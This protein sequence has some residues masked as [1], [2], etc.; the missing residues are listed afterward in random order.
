MA[1]KSSLSTSHTQENEQGEFTLRNSGSSSMDSNNNCDHD[2]DGKTD[3]TFTYE[4]S[5]PSFHNFICNEPFPQLLTYD[6]FAI[7]AA[8]QPENHAPEL[9]H[10]RL[11][12]DS[13]SQQ[14]FST[15]E[16]QNPRKRTRHTL[17]EEGLSWQNAQ[18]EKQNSLIG[19]SPFT[20]ICL[21][22]D[23]ASLPC[24]VDEKINTQQGPTEGQGDKEQVE[25]IDLYTDKKRKQE[26]EDAQL[27]RVLQQQIDNEGW[28]QIKRDEELAKQLAVEWSSGSFVRSSASSS[29]PTKNPL[30]SVISNK[31]IWDKANNS[32]CE[33]SIF[34]DSSN[35]TLQ[36]LDFNIETSSITDNTDIKNEIL[37]MTSIISPS[38]DLS[39]SEQLSDEFDQQPV[40]P[41][42]HINEDEKIISS[43]E[44]F[45]APPF[46]TSSSSSPPAPL[47]DIKPLTELS[48]SN[49]QTWLNS[50]LN[51]SIVNNGVGSSI[52]I[53]EDSNENAEY[54]YSA[55]G[56]GSSLE[57]NFLD[58]SYANMYSGST[59]SSMIKKTQEERLRALLED[60]NTEEIIQPQDRTG[61][62]ENLIPTLMEHQV[63]GLSWLKKKEDS[64]NRGGILAD[65]MGLGKTVQSIALILARPS[66]DSRRRPTLVVAPVSLLSQWANEFETK[67]RGLTV[68]VHHGKNKIKN[69][70]LLQN[71]DV[72]IT[73]YTIIAAE[74]D[75]T[76]KPI[77]KNLWHRV[78][79]DEAQTIKNQRT[80]AAKGCCE[81]NSTY[82][83]C[84]SGTP[85]QN[86]IE[87]LYSLIKF[88]QIE[89]YCEW[90]EF[91]TNFV[92]PFSR[93]HHGSEMVMK[94]LRVVLKSIL[95]RRTKTSMMDGK[96]IVNLPTR[97][98]N[99]ANTEFSEEE[100]EFYTSLESR[101]RLQ[102]NRYLSE[103]SVMKNYSNI[104]LLLLRLRQACCHPYL[105]TDRNVE[106]MEGESSSHQKSSSH[107][108]IAVLLEK[109]AEDIVNRLKEQDLE[110]KECA[111]CCDLAS[112]LSIIV[113]CGHSYCRECLEGLNQKSAR[114][115]K[116]CPE[117]RGK[118]D[119]KEVV[120]YK[121]FKK[122]WV[123]STAIAPESL[124]KGKGK[125]KAEDF[126]NPDEVDL[127]DTTQKGDDWVTSS[128][129]DR[130]INLLLEFRNKAPKDKTIIFSQLDL[131]EQPLRQN[132]FKYTRYD[133]KIKPQQRNEAINAFEER[134]D[135]NVMLVSLRCGGVGL[136]LTTANRVI[137]LDPWWNP[138][139]ENQAIDRVHRI[140]Q[141][142]PVEVH[143]III[144][145]TIE[146]RIL[147][148]QEAK[149]QLASKVL[150]EGG[151]A[152]LGRLGLQDLMY[153]FQG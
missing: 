137:M 91:K 50:V 126:E 35:S 78:I 59:S 71:Y 145:N 90:I 109:M 72:V 62:P 41:S 25:V 127:P 99:I 31:I 107:E 61:T 144:P 55:F 19:L 80:K 85:I 104:L 115:M 146:K 111:I 69:F 77:S 74:H 105:I 129:I 36:S 134:P 15:L 142:K 132:G 68:F 49:T 103:G 17:A 26:E 44:S 1:E 32:P 93:G 39:H 116:S 57:E 53:N 76:S 65:D 119:M 45:S 112:D 10:K 149:Q 150:G 64:I 106:N 51:N 6:C 152:P 108:D 139:M 27:A 81:L 87:E 130:T 54:L 138:A 123:S 118:L 131:V 122:K 153:L 24:F 117:C 70:K 52:T 12:P 3:L 38:S 42:S 29:I 46:S 128:K 143:R 98:V 5:G 141:Q 88:L 125:A 66:T 120:S 110:H 9:S 140:G 8:I 11:Y 100:R 34:T 83:W 22:D 101:S 18:P 7:N 48:S 28:E 147:D 133:G 33:H 113:R 102:F 23:D 13:P 96:P 37:A 67:T 60:I 136:N 40:Q 43:S 21:T 124:E 20:S 114:E 135:L 121:S 148:L 4:G 2:Q 79:L 86:N 89:P 14:S 56:S 84:L 97:E 82:R 16:S 94:R 63:I 58:Y 151:T 95:L 73:S 92:K 47:P 75:L 30:S